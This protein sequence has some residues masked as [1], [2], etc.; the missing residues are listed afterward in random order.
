MLAGMNYNSSNIYSNTR[1]DRPLPFSNP[2][3]QVEDSPFRVTKSNFRATNRGFSANRGKQG[4]GNHFQQPS[5]PFK[6]PDVW[7]S[8]P[9]ME[10][11]QPSIQKT[12]KVSSVR[13]NNIRNGPAKK[14]NE[15]DKKTFLNDRYPNG[16]GPDSNLIEMLEKEVLDKSP[17]IQFDDIADL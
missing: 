3:I 7:D 10:K 12:N 13:N 2:S 17:N 8:P 1:N 11:R 16:S 6:D 9:P 15:G 4:G 5:K 14:K